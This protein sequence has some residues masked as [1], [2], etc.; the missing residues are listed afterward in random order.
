MIKKTILLLFAFV[1]VQLLLLNGV[2]SLQVLTL[3]TNPVL[4]GVSPFQDEQVTFTFETDTILLSLFYELVGTN[5]A[6]PSRMTTDGSDTQSFT[7]VMPITSLLNY[8]LPLVFNFYDV[9]SGGNLVGSITYNPVPTTSPPLY[10]TN[11]NVTILPNLVHML[12]LPGEADVGPYCQFTFAYKVYNEL[13]GISSFFDSST[14]NGYPLSIYSMGRSPYVIEQ[15]NEYKTYVFTGGAAVQTSNINSLTFYNYFGSSTSKSISGLICQSYN[16]PNLIN[17]LNLIASTVE[18]IVL[19]SFQS[20][21]SFGRMFAYR[22]DDDMNMAQ[23][24]IT[25][26]LFNYNNNSIYYRWSKAAA[27]YQNITLEV[28]GYPA[29]SSTTISTSPYTQPTGITFTVTC[30]SLSTLLPLPLSIVLQ[31]NYFSIIPDQ[32]YINI[33]VLVNLMPG[34]DQNEISVIT[35]NIGS[36]FWVRDKGFKTVP[37]KTILSVST[38]DARSSVLTSTLIFKNGYTL[39]KQQPFKTDVYTSTSA[40][41]AIGAMENFQFSKTSN[42]LYHYYQVE[43]NITDIPI[44]SI[45]YI[46][47]YCQAGLILKPTDYT[48]SF[49]DIAIRDG[50]AFPYQFQGTRTIMRLYRKSYIPMDFQASNISLTLGSIQNFLIDTN[51]FNIETDLQAPMFQLQLKGDY[52]VMDIQDRLGIRD[53]W[54][55]VTFGGETMNVKSSNRLRGT[56]SDGSYL[57]RIPGGWKPHYC[58][59]RPSV[60]CRDIRGNGYQNLDYDDT[61]QVSSYQFPGYPPICAVST[62][63]ISRLL[64]IGYQFVD[65]QSSVVF[66][67]IFST[68]TAATVANLKLILYTDP[69]NT[70]IAKEMPMNMVQ[71]TGSFFEFT[72]TNIFSYPT[73]TTL[74]F[75][76]DYTQAGQSVHLSTK[77]IK[78]HFILSTDEPYSTKPSSNITIQSINYKPLPSIQILYANL[79]VRMLIDTATT[80]AVI[81]NITLTQLFSQSLYPIYYKW[82]GPPGVNGGTYDIDIQTSNACGPNSKVYISSIC[83][84]S[85]NCYQFGMYGNWVDI[86]NVSLP[87]VN[88]LPDYSAEFVN[89]SMV[90][91]NNQGSISIDV[92]SNNR[93]FDVLFQITK[94]SENF[95]LANT[96]NQLTPIVYLTEM[97]SNEKLEFISALTVASPNQY[98]ATIDIPVN[99]GLRGVELSVW[100]ILDNF[101]GV[102]GTNYID[103]NLTLYSSSVMNQIPYIWNSTL[104]FTLKRVFV[105]GSNFGYPI[106]VMINSNRLS[107]MIRLS[108]NSIDISSLAIDYTQPITIGVVGS[109]YTNLLSGGTN[110]KC[111]RNCSGHGECSSGTCIC[112]IPWTGDD[113]SIDNS[114][115]CPNNCSGGNGQCLDRLCNCNTNFT[116]PDC[117]I[118][119]VTTPKPNYNI[120]IQPTEPTANFNGFQSQS[121]STNYEISL[122]RIDEINLIGEVIF[123]YNLTGLWQ[124][125]EQNS[126]YTLY[127]I[128]SGVQPGNP[129]SWVTVQVHPFGEEGGSIEW[130]NNTIQMA[131]RSVKYFTYINGYKFDQ[132]YNQLELVWQNMVVADRVCGDDSI[133]VG[134]N[135]DDMHWYQLPANQLIL[136]GRFS[137]TILL[138]NKPVRSINKIAQTENTAYIQT[139]IPYFNENVLIDPDFSVLVD[140]EKETECSDQPGFPTWK[141]AVI[142]VAGVIFIALLIVENAPVTKLILIIV[143]GS[144]LVVNYQANKLKLVSGGTST[145]TNNNNNNNN[146][147]VTLSNLSLITLLLNN[148]YFTTIGET[149]LGSFLLYSFR[150]FERTMGS[151]KYSFFAVISIIISTLIHIGYLVVFKKG[152]SPGPYSFI[153]SCLV[154][155]YKDIP[156]TYWFKLLKF[157]LNDKIFSY[158]L[159]L[160]MM[161]SYPNAFANCLSGL[162]AGILY[163]TDIFSL[164]NKRFPKWMAALCNRWITPLLQSNQRPTSLRTLMELQQRQRRHQQ[165]QQQQQR[166]HTPIVPS[167]INIATLESMGFPRERV[168][169]ALQ[170][171][172]NNLNEATNYL[173]SAI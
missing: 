18:P 61:N 10:T 111:L 65:T 155:F 101:G 102:F 140:Y 162:I 94:S 68:P 133:Q 173:L 165:T 166:Q 135:L 106:E 66:S 146:I 134:G 84:E 21:S 142:V 53:N 108:D 17:N 59:I 127:N 89:V 85:E 33:N 50:T 12:Y 93:K 45:P 113:C 34:M 36:T 105:E 132:P 67:V 161:Y 122:V 151:S 19:S 39:M 42:Q 24:I 150:L 73:T 158:I 3:K 136:Y 163:Y 157:P 126:N 128:S 49:I 23:R 129:M 62:N 148:L 46:N 137:D 75:G 32:N 156:A 138:D 54:C 110:Q 120:T 145:T 70:V 6:S 48:A 131:P 64:H 80:Y 141:I 5:T 26:T 63:S 40:S 57:L 13:V 27:D 119:L 76:L 91:A 154:L 25:P 171:S 52:F 58:M 118:S 22:N 79:K 41:Q 77:D 2:N 147:E 82:T 90:R 97:L 1:V 60:S 117:S 99:W 31:S 56:V 16:P 121:V 78:Y 143:I 88:A 55:N 123:S 159:S 170:M 83:D 96:S 109:N 144:S 112:N 35:F 104:D 124:L 15:T 72:K 37:Y 47:V 153:F 38:R 149:V 172:N 130:M 164:K 100:R 169:E 29:N 95:Q 81:K 28:P 87:C 160:Q 44:G 20:I 51:L 103:F 14:P 74:Y 139:I 152:G 98:L 7:T 4:S 116:G 9:N 71:S 168:I 69:E 114:Y 92:S 115:T 125:V 43:T 30:S 167:D 86:G 107:T 8:G 11:T